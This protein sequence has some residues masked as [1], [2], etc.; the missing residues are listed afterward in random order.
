[1]SAIT[2]DRLH[3]LIDALGEDDFDTVGRLLT[4]LV[5]DDP[6]GVALALAPVDDEPETDEERAAVAE[7][8]EDLA[9]GRVLTTDELRRSLGL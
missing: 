3:E 7:A 5:D 9:A 2:R 8:R 1:M 4:A 6:V